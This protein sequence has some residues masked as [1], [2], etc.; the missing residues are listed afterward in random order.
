MAKVTI[1]ESD[2]I[3]ALGAI[4]R[5]RKANPLRAG[6]IASVSCST[7]IYTTGVK[8]GFTLTHD[9]VNGTVTIEEAASV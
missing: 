9:K 3:E 6:E 2:L 1:N 7:E 5:L 4:A 8:R